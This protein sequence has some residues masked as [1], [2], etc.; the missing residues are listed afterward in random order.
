MIE[1]KIEGLGKLKR[2]LNP[3]LIAKAEPRALNKTAQLSRTAESK[4]IRKT[5]NIKAK[6]LN[7]ELEKISGGNR[8]TVSRPR[9]IIRGKKLTKRNPG[10]QNYG[11]RQTSKGVS[12][13]IRKDLGRKTRAHA[14]IATMPKGGSGV[15]LRAG[16]S[17]VMTRGK[18]IGKKRQ[19]IIRQTG[20][21]VVQ[22][23]E[24]IGIKPISTTVTKN[25]S[26]LFIHEYNRELLKAKR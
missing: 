7:R 16:K 15:F 26:R 9:A 17:R 8:A 11:T 21:S 4:E 6:R 3:K 20:P 1:F 25:Y 2:L 23:M 24:R 22:M 14:F 5:Y 13:R 19:G 10:L 12:Y 18:Y